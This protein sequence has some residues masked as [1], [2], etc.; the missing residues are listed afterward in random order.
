MSSITIT[1]VEFGE[2]TVITMTA[3]EIEQ[4]LKTDRHLNYRVVFL[5]KTACWGKIN[6]FMSHPT[7]PMGGPNPMYDYFKRTDAE[8]A[9]LAAKLADRDVEVAE[10]TA[11]LAVRDAEVAE[12]ASK[13]APR[14][15]RCLFWM[16]INHTV[17]FVFY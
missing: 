1:T 6:E 13:L 11:K 10:L 9:G 15:H 8:K 7:D 3:L 5:S 16:P 4:M 14:T 17:M 2:T 12:I